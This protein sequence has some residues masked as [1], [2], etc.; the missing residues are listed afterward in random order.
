LPQQNPY[1]Y[2][3]D[4]HAEAATTKLFCTIAGNKSTEYVVH[5]YKFFVFKYRTIY[6]D[7]ERLI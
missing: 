5:F 1:Y 4:D 7:F 6:S 3:N 2:K